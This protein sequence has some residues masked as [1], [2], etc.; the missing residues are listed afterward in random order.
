LKIAFYFKKK[1][2]ELR[3]TSFK[4]SHAA[5]SPPLQTVGELLAVFSCFPNTI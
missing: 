2:K 4:T 5:F 1:K 3:K